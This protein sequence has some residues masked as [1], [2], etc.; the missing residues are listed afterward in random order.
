MIWLYLLQVIDSL[1]QVFVAAGVVEIPP[2]PA[3]LSE[4]WCHPDFYFA[5]SGK[6]LPGCFAFQ[7]AVPSATFLAERSVSDPDLIWV[8]NISAADFAKWIGGFFESAQQKLLPDH[9]NT[10]F[11]LLPDSRRRFSGFETGASWKIMF[12]GV[13]CGRLTLYSAFPGYSSPDRAAAALILDVRTLARL[14]A[15]ETN[16]EAVHWSSE[17][18]FSRLLAAHAW[19]RV[20]DSDRVAGSELMV[21]FEKLISL[22]DTSIERAICNLLQF[23]NLYAR[24]IGRNHEVGQL[25]ASKLRTLREQYLSQNSGKRP[26]AAMAGEANA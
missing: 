24:S 19:H 23:Y 18:P 7:F 20:D 15:S 9:E 22:Q 4:P 26:A 2:F 16:S 11:S 3:P 5:M 17:F 14:T 13:E 10:V 6:G 1:R 21:L 12:T 25:F 8:E